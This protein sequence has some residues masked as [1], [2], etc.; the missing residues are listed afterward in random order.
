MASLASASR[1]ARR[2]WR[3]VGWSG[4]RGHAIA[5][6][7]MAAQV[8]YMTAPAISHITT[9]QIGDGGDGLYDLW[10]IVWIRGWIEGQHGLYFTHQ[11]FAPGGANLAW[12]T[13]ALPANL[14]AALISPLLGLVGSYNVM[15]LLCQT[16]NGIAMYHLARSVRVGWLAGIAGGAAFIGSGHLVAE[17]LGHIDLLQAFLLVW[18]VQLLWGILEVPN[19]QWVRVLCLGAL[20]GATFYAIQDYAL[21][22]L[23]ASVLLFLAHPAIRGIRTLTLIGRW[24]EWLL[25]AG[26]AI[27]VTFPLWTSMLWG[28]LSPT[29]STAAQSATTPYLVD[30][31]E[32]IIPA[33]WGPF[34]WLQSHWDLSAGLVEVAFPGFLVLGALY[35]ALRSQWPTPRGQ[36]GLLQVSLIGIGTFGVLELGPYL[37]VD[38]IATGVPMPYLFLSYIPGWSVSLPVRLSVL[39]ALFGSLLVGV[40]GDRLIVRVSSWSIVRKAG[41]VAGAV[42]LLALGC[43]WLPFPLAPVPRIAGAAEIRRAGGEVLFAPAVVPGTDIGQGPVAYMYVDAV[44]GLP[45]PEGDV[46]RIPITTRLKVDGSTV[47]RFLWSLQFHRTAGKSLR[48]AA[49]RDLIRYLDRHRVGS[50]V[51]LRSEIRAPGPLIAWLRNELAIRYRVTWFRGEVVFIRSRTD[52]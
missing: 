50:I 5:W 33:P 40:M 44:L 14:G 4:A 7:I 39:T 25:A 10:D 47:L 45:T 41:L 34:W 36:E 43:S 23:A 8:L 51:V 42:G 28:P 30:L 52:G 6:L 18:F 13:L 29:L 27:A 15:V 38:G 31:V 1:S 35:A 26:V 9:L 37:H 17:M 48:R 46:S 2:P 12:M 32:F 49:G 20:W 21:Y 11:L 24:R 19:P 16:L 22:Q 3:T